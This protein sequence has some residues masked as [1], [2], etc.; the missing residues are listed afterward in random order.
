[1]ATIRDLRAAEARRRDLL[2]I[3]PTASV[4]QKYHHR[5]SQRMAEMVGLH[6]LNERMAEMVELHRLNE[7]MAEAA[8]SQIT[9]TMLAPRLREFSR[10]AE[11]LS[12]QLG[13]PVE[14]V[15]GDLHGSEALTRTPDVDWLLLSQLT[16]R[17]TILAFF[18]TLVV[19]VWEE[20]ADTAP[21]Q[22]L[23]EIIGALV[24]W[25]QIDDAVWK[26]IS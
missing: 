17:A 23:L 7:Q 21:A 3:T 16:M 13:S 20:Q 2:T 25:Y 4:I 24:L 9:A 12:E 10:Q 6:R 1:M 19:A 18:L 14:P 15:D 11:L 8:G 5:V 26:K 22:A